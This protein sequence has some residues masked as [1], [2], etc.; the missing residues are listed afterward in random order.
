MEKIVSLY[1]ALLLLIGAVAFAES[2]GSSIAEKKS[3]KT[4]TCDAAT[5]A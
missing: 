1:T 2:S 4:K 3:F 5:L